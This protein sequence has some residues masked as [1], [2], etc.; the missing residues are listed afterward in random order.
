MEHFHGMVL[1]DNGVAFVHEGVEAPWLGEGGAGV[2][3]P[4]PEDGAEAA[5]DVGIEK[6][7][8][9]ESK[10]DSFIFVT[11]VIV[12][13]KIGRVC[14]SHPG[15]QGK[16][17]VCS[18]HIDSNPCVSSHKTAYFESGVNPLAGPDV[19]VEVEKGRME[20]GAVLL[21]LELTVHVSLFDVLGFESR[22]EPP[23]L[24]EP[25]N[26]S[27]NPHVGGFKIPDGSSGPYISGELKYLVKGQGFHTRTGVTQV[28]HKIAARRAWFFHDVG[29]ADV[30]VY[31]GPHA[32]LKKAA[33]PGPVIE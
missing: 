22:A 25:E 14:E 12:G 26:F 10:I 5:G 23:L 17:L 1:H 31:V 27:S 16:I 28:V 2:A 29:G 18:A 3:R 6:D 19:G 4:W 32:S 15:A 11:L 9:G 33:F 24:K 7:A 8:Q 20:P 21:G 30:V 13:H